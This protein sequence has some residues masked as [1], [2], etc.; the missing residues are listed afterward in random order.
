MVAM[1]AWIAAFGSGVVGKRRG[2]E[3]GR[4]RQGEVAATPGI[5]NSR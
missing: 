4:G 3:E 1:A 5:P 2:E